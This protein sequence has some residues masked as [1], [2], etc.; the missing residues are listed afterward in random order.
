MAQFQCDEWGRK[1]SV[2]RIQGF[3]F[4]RMGSGCEGE[5]ISLTPM[6]C[7]LQDYDSAK[8]VA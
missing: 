6:S 4:K 1:R 8:S 2:E 7:T 5:R 3:L